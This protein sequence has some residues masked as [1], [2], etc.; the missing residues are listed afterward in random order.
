MQKSN[1]DLNDNIEKHLIE[2]GWYAERKIDIKS[3]IEI[4]KADNYR[5]FDSA[6]FLFKALMS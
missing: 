3:V 6:I 1:F 4:W 2:Y 5:V